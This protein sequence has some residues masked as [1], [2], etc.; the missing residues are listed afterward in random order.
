[1]HKDIEGRVI[2]Y[3]TVL[4]LGDKTFTPNPHCRV[5]CAWIR[6]KSIYKRMSEE[7]RLRLSNLIYGS[8]G[9]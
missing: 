8:D 6:A 1:M 2:D 4:V 7:E 5:R 3:L 9:D